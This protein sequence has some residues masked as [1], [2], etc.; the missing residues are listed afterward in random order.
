MTKHVLTGLILLATAATPIAAQQQSARSISASDKRQGASANPQLVAQFGGRYTGP[1]AAYVERVGK[2]VAVQSGLSNATGDFTVTTLNSPVEN[3]FAIPGGYVYVTRQ[4]LALMNSEAELAS[5]LGHEVG[6]VAARHS[7]GRQTRSTIGSILAAGAGLLTGSNL[8]TQVVGQGA[9]LYT[10]KYGRD[11]EYQADALGV[12]YITAAGYDPYAAADMLSALG[13]SSSLA[14]RSA[15]RDGA[16]AI[17]TWASTHPNSQDRVVRA[18]KLAAAT[19]RA[20]PAAVQDTAFL[21]MLDGLPY[22]DDP[23]QG[24]VDGQNFRHPGLR[25]R[26]AAPAGYRIANGDDAVTIA[27]NGGQAQFE[28]STAS[29]PDAA[30]GAR[31]RA[32]GAPADGETQAGSVNGLPYAYRTVRA[33]ANGRAVDATV[34]AYRF[35][36]GVYTFTLVTPAGSGIGPFQPLLSSVAPLSA[37]DAAAIRG[38]V[39]RIVTVGPRDTIDSLSARMAYPN[40]RRE[41]FVTLNGLDASEPLRPGTLVKLVV[42]R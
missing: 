19:G 2:R 39:V 29:T 14:A 24:V 37:T 4:L 16:A 40:L 22:D 17:P 1:Q 34:V 42:N 21:R 8:A 31:F 11:Q 25:V 18:E 12:R 7:Q 32:L 41:R 26:F 36:A 28:T 27:G 30:I 9:Q 23:A 6:H 38:K 5:V 13:A 20:E 33:S 10:L 15:G 35:P 3:A